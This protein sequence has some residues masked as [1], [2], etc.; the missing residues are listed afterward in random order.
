MGNQHLASV[1]DQATYA[2]CPPTSGSHFNAVDAPLPRAFY[3]PDKAEKPGNWIHNLEH[4]D[5]V[6]LYRG[7]PP[8]SDLDS[9]RTVMDA[10]PPGSRAEAC[11]LP[12]P[13][14]VVRFDDMTAPFALVSWDRAM[15]LDAW[16]PDRAKTFLQQWETNPAVPEKPSATC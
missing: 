6:I 3:G 9:L 14:I 11:S 16:D 12:N 8:Q 4:G 13:A 10:V 15:L 7:T 5:I 1:N 2:F